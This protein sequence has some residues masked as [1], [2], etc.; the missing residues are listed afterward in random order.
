MKKHSQHPLIIDGYYFDKVQKIIDAIHDI[1]R[2]GWVNRHVKNPETVGEHTD[3]LV[4]LAEDLFDVPDLNIM[5]KIH[6]WA[7][8]DPTVGDIRTDRFCPL[9][10]RRSKEEKYAMELRAMQKICVRLGRYGLKIFNLWWEYEVRETYR[11][12][13]AFQL[14]KFQMIMKAI[15]YQKAGE[16]VIAQEFIDNNGDD[17]QDDRLKQ[18]ILA[19]QSEL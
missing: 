19:A 15:A 18:M 16:P 12:K 7:E 14:D 17:V 3:E 4:N 1:P 5:L 9:D 6:D 10:Q 11:A 8:S 13:I 2:T